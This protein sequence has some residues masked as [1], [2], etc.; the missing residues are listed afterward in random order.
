MEAT[1]EATGYRFD[2]LTDELLKP[3]EVAVILGCSVPKVRGLYGEGKLLAFKFGRHLVR[4]PKSE[5]TRFLNA[6]KPL[7]AN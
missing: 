2:W 4:I 3:K 1:R 5:A 6:K 7:M